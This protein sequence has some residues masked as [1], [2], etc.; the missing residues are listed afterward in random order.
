MVGPAGL[1]VAASFTALAAAAVR[2]LRCLQHPFPN[3]VCRMQDNIH[4]YDAPFMDSRHS[5]KAKLGTLPAAP[6]VTL[7][8]SGSSS[9]CVCITTPMQMQVQAP[10]SLM[11]H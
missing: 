2:A 7:L 3:H 5:I 4:D 11:C 10:C 1:A 9:W 6:S 8:Q